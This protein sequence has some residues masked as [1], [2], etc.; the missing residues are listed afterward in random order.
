MTTLLAAPPAFDAR[1][2]AA[3][4]SAQLQRSN[5]FGPHLAVQRDGLGAEW[6]GAT[7]LV[8]SVV[9]SPGQPLDPGVRSVMETRLGHDFSHVRVHTDDDAARSADAI[10]AT[11]YTAGNHIVFGAGQFAPAAPGGQRVVAHELAH[12]IQQSQGPVAGTDLG[13]G[14]AVSHP[15]DPFEREAVGLAEQATKAPSIERKLGAAAIAPHNSGATRLAVQ[16]QQEGPY[17]KAGAWAGAFGALFGL[18]A[19]VVALY[20]WLKPNQ[21]ATGQGVTMGPSNP[22]QLPT[23]ASPP[24]DKAK[25]SEREDYQNAVQAPPTVS[26]VLELRTDEDNYQI[27]Q[28][29]RK[30]DKKHLISAMVTAGDHKGYEGGGNGS[31]ATVNFSAMQSAV[32]T[33]SKPQPKPAPAPKKGAPSKGSSDATPS[34]APMDHWVIDFSGTNGESRSGWSALFGSRTPLQDFEGQL[35]VKGN[36]D[37]SC[38]RC[39][40]TNNIGRAEVK[41]TYGLVDYRSLKPVSHSNQSATDAGA[42][43]EHEKQPPSTPPKPGPGP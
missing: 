15:E 20:A 40:V 32:A 37:V 4:R 12:V 14:V 26:T 16:R 17:T 8:R 36:G 5:T 30:T 43:G 11:A 2:S 1:R 10:G 39:A 31:T 27:F 9:S 6:D 13:D 42:S 35:L 7:G 38:T 24:G 3:S 21:N 23:T 34:E 41:G 19:L 33:A 28:L 25:E 22:Y 29:Q 18:G